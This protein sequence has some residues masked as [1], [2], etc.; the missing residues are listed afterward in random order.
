MGSCLCA[1]KEKQKEK[2]K[3]NILVCACSL[4]HLACWPGSTWVSWWY[5]NPSPL[6]PLCSALCL[7]VECAQ[8]GAFEADRWES[9][10]TEDQPFSL[11]VPTSR[12]DLRDISNYGQSLHRIWLLIKMLH[13]VSA[14]SFS[15]SLEPP[16][17]DVE[18]LREV[19]G[20]EGKLDADGLNPGVLQILPKYYLTFPHLYLLPGSV[21][22]DDPRC[23]CPYLLW[24]EWSCTEK[25]EVDFL[26]LPLRVPGGTIPHYLHHWAT[27][28]AKTGSLNLNTFWW[29]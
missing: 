12:K 21:E 10:E 22:K 20:G 11:P 8:L 26:V 18:S 16:R 5:H 3:R 27:H 29:K 2:E 13:L 6:H 1:K 23:V 19:S 24:M 14:C 9:G 17:V 4:F 7:H 25:R 28:A 15:L